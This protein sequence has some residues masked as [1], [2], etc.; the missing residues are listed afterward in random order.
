MKRDPVEAY[1]EQLKGA[2]AFIQDQ[3]GGDFAAMA[4]DVRRHGRVMGWPTDM[5]EE[6][7]GDL[8]AGYDRRAFEARKN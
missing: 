3:F 6:I 1:N 8:R 5:V 7:I 2:E 4:E